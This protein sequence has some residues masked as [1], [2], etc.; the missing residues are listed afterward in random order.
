MAS[1]YNLPKLKQSEIENLN[2]PKAITEIEFRVKSLQPGV[3][4]ALSFGPCSIAPPV[5]V[6]P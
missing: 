1:K 4:R 2:G 3:V 5:C 6:T